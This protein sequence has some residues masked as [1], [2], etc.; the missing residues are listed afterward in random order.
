VTSDPA[1]EN[2]ACSNYQCENPQTK[3]QQKH[4]G[5]HS[6]LAKS[7]DYA[8]CPYDPGTEACSLEKR[9][10]TGSRKSAPGDAN[11][12]TFNYRGCEERGTEQDDAKDQ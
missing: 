3:N 11:I 4:I 10:A 5:F 1:G 8:H 12:D 7:D 2:I 9:R 6:N